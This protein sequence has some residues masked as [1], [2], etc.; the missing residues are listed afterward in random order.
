VAE[1]LAEVPLIE[2]E[3]GYW[4]R[5]GALRAKALSTQRKAR[6]GDALIAQT[7]VDSGIALLTRDKD[8]QAFMR[9]ARLRL[10]L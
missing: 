10:V 9:T 3:A 7:C 2:L 1:T 6:L 4:Q 5:A 8:F